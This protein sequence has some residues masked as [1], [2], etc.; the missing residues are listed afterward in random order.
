MQMGVF[1]RRYEVSQLGGGERGGTR[2]LL[3]G[4]FNFFF[5]GWGKERAAATVLGHTD[6][7]PPPAPRGHLRRGAGARAGPARRL[8]DPCGRGGAA[9]GIGGA[10][11]GARAQAGLATGGRAGRAVPADRGRS[12]RSTRARGGA[13]TPRAEPQL[14][15][16]ERSRRCDGAPPRGPRGVRLGGRRLRW[17]PP[18]AHGAHP[19]RSHRSVSYR[20]LSCRTTAG[21]RR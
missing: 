16:H 8:A 14:P 6:D 4:D 20:H 21:R 17:Q 18:V 19:P 11:G 15:G 10:P 9:G 1:A 2:N 3:A 13:A 5:S 12:V 7:E